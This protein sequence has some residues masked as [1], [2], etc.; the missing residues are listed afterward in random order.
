MSETALLDVRGVTRTYGKLRAVSDLSF[1]LAPGQVVGFIGPNGAGKTTTMRILATLDLPDEG[2]AFVD[3]R[4]VLVEPRAVRRRVGFMADTF[5]PWANLDVL[6]FLD[7]VARAHGLRGRARVRAVRSVASFCGLLEFADRPA[8]GLSKGMGQRLHLAK[9]LLH[10]PSLLILD[11]PTAGLDPR[12]RIEFRDLVGELA[13]A[14]KG[15]LI[16]SHIL[17]EL[18]E[19]C[20]SILVIE[21]GQRVVAGSIQEIARGLAPHRRV[22]VRVAGDAGEALKFL[23]TQPGVREAAADGSAVGFDFEGDEEAL[24]GLLA[25]AVGAGL[26]VFEFHAA[27]ADLED[28]FLRTTKGRLQ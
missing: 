26:K 13:A 11:E 28:I 25:R 21:R 7:F 4:S 14:G 23:L 22:G 8:S 27:V 10:D 16:S 18:A 2:D 3:G 1:S 20:D 12:A 6:Q 17:T 5:V 9:T 19:S 15:I 24:A